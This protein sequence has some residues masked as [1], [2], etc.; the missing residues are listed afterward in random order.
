MSH[1]KTLKIVASAILASGLLLSCRSRKEVRPEPAMLSL[2]AQVL[3]LDYEKNELWGRNAEI[4]VFVTESG[5]TDICTGS[6]NIRYQTVFSTGILSLSPTDEPIYLP[7]EGELIDISAYYPYKA[8]L[9]QANGY[10]YVYHVDLSDQ[11]ALDPDIL[12]IAKTER[13][14]SVL[15]TA[16]LTLKPAFAK[17]KV[18]LNVREA[19][20]ASGKDVQLSVNGIPCEA[21]IDILSGEYL[22]YGKTESTVMNMPENGIHSYEAVVL[23][24]TTD[25]NA[26]LTVSFGTAGNIEDINI[27]LKDLIDVFAPNRQ[28]D[29]SVTVS[30]DGIEAILVGMSD[31]YVSDWKTDY[32]DVNGEV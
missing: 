4:G 9:T 31:F 8:E 11:D 13:R 7:E 23:A 3:S 27:G 32:E 28:Y 2:S 25:D 14:N 17:M 10:P 6:E 20:K 19:T 24:H 5:T 18:S 29:L 22:S 12:L 16:M 30:P 21:D 1:T 26:F 15:H